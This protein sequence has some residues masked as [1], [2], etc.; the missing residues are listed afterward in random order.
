M[1]PIPRL[2]PY[3][4]PALF[5][6]G[7]RP[8]FLFGALYAGLAVM[9]WLP[10]YCGE[11]TLPTAFAP[12]DWHIHEMLY[13]YVPAVMTGFLLTAIPNWTGRLPLQGTPLI[14]LVIGWAAGRLAVTF[15]GTIGWLPALIVD[16]SFLVL[17][18]VAAARE[19]VAGRT[20]RN[21]MIVGLV[22]LLA[23]GNICFHLES[24]VSGAADHST[25]AGLAVVIILI[26]LIG[27]RIVPSFTHNWLVRENPGRLPVPFGRFDMIVVVASAAAVVTW[28]AQ[29]ATTT[30]G[31][32]LVVAG[33]LQLLRFSRWA[34]DRTLR[35]PL[36]LILHIG[37]AFVPLG[38]LLTGLAAFDLIPAASGIHAF[39]GG[40]IGTMTLAVMTRA[41]LGHTGRAL[42]A[43]SGTQAIYVAIVLAALV[44]I[45][46]TMVPQQMTVLLALAAVLWSAA[47]VGFGIVYGPVV[48]TQRPV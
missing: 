12:R 20:W 47:F 17:V 40:A 42:Y 48:A 28:I 22:S 9:L 27:G 6:Y 43:S 5:S 23:A 21:L 35:E 38:F 46:A 11:I 44:R 31:Y 39:A 16:A 8:F 36:V 24:H 29:P 18:A 14:V 2:K 13:G 7:F 19:V 4:G 26:T 33:L 10:V 3:E 25:R 1:A 30:T 37:Y 34:G 32:A 45:I 15:S 41:S